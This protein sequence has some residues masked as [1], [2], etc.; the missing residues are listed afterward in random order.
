MEQGMPLR[1]TSTYGDKGFEADTSKNAHYKANLT[2]TQPGDYP[3]H[4]TIREYMNDK[5]EY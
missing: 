2:D 5:I 1:D 4:D 3:R